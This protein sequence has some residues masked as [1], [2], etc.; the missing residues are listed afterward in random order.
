LLEHLTGVPVQSTSKYRTCV[1]IQTDTDP[2]IIIMVSDVDMHH[3]VYAAGV[4]V[5]VYPRAS[6]CRM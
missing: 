2:K 6:S 4:S 3:V 1:H 5:T